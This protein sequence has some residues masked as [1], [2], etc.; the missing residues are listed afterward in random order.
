MDL[1]LRMLQDKNLE[2]QSLK[3]ER[4]NDGPDSPR[5]RSVP[6]TST[7]EKDQHNEQNQHAAGEIPQFH[8]DDQQQQPAANGPSALLQQHLL[9]DEDL[10]LFTEEEEEEDEE[11]EDVG[12]SHFSSQF[13]LSKGEIK[14]RKR[15]VPR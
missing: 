9:E 12:E 10:L 11:E 15:V 4:K 3:L 7:P 13:S 5:K 8:I 14:T 1:L 6:A 2:R